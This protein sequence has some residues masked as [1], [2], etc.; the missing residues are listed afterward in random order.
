[1]DGNQPYI[2]KGRNT[3]TARKSTHRLFPHGPNPI[4]LSRDIIKRK[5]DEIFEPKSDELKACNSKKQKIDQTNL[6]E[7]IE[8]LN[9]LEFSWFERQ[10]YD[11]ELEKFKE[12]LKRVSATEKKTKLDELDQNSI[13]HLLSQIQDLRLICNH[14][15]LLLYLGHFCASKNND[16]NFLLKIY[17]ISMFLK[18]FT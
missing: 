4:L 5:F 14:P 13:M 11:S 12:T 10:L 17:N 16:V 1:M 18:N 7:Q 15:K 9:L 3:M 6:P 8:N 2:P